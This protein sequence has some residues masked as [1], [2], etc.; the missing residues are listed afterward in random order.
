MPERR[1]STTRE[2]ARLCAPLLA[3]REH[4]KL[5]RIS[6]QSAQELLL[7]NPTRRRFHSQRKIPDAPSCT[8]TLRA[9]RALR[10]IHHSQIWDTQIMGA[11]RL[12][13][14]RAMG[15]TTRQRTSNTQRNSKPTRTRSSLED[16]YAMRTSLHSIHPSTSSR[17][18]RK[19]S[20]NNSKRTLSLG[21]ALAHPS[22]Q[23][24]QE[25]NEARFSRTQLR[26]CPGR[27]RLFRSRVWIS[28]IRGA[29]PTCQPNDRAQMS[30]PLF[31]YRRIC[32]RRRS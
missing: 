11:P 30:M 9:R 4:I 10:R 31:S 32:W 29:S 28:H 12:F 23:K 20:I 8:G 7:I 27:R 13:T 5:G 16:Q 1:A 2:V 15:Q 21:D 17:M 24:V 19:R 18:S 3:K 25:P 14:R 6:S 26:R 22:C